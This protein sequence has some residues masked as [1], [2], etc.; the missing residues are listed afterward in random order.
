MKNKYVFFALLVCIALLPSCNKKYKNSDGSSYSNNKGVGGS[1]NDLLSESKYSSIK[2]E[3]QYMAGFAPD[4]SAVNLLKDFLTARLNKSVG[5]TVVQ[6]EI[7]ASSNG[8]L[9]VQQ[10]ADI[11]K[12]NRTVFT[13]DKELGVYFL[14]TNGGYSNANVLGVAYNNTSMCLF[15]KTINDNSG[16]VGQASRTKLTATVLEHEFGHILG[17]VDVG[18]KMQTNH[19]D[20]PNGA[21]CNNKDCL[22]YYAVETTDVLGFLITGNIPT[23]DANCLADL[24]LNG[25]K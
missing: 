12:E 11:E 2:I 9:T 3:I 23:L 8:T 14:F 15:G 1:A 13:T 5:I 16:N 25:G 18:S 21:H 17:L 6:K 10:V 4:A 22:M 19:K 20:S 7:P 24:K